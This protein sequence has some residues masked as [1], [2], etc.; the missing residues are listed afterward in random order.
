MEEE[1]AGTLEL[2]VMNTFYV[3]IYLVFKVPQRGFAL[4]SALAG[5]PVQLYSTHRRGSGTCSPLR[6]LAVSRVATRWRCDPSYRS[7]PRVPAPAAA[8]SCVLWAP[9]SGTSENLAPGSETRSKNA[10]FSMDE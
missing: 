4:R 1:T 10:D 7:Q 3:Y 6:A 9:P 2:C 8:P 5:S